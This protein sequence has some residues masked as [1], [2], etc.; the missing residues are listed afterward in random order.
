MRGV[1]LRF[2]SDVLAK[3]KLIRLA[4]LAGVLAGLFAAGKATGVIDNVSI[5][6]VRAYIESAGP[7]G[8]LVFIGAF[9]VGQLVYLPGMA[10][11]AAGILVYGK[12]L[13]FALGWIAAVISVNFSFILVRAVGGKALAEVERPL[14]RKMMAR[15]DRHPITTVTVL[16]TI[17]AM[18][19]AL[20]YA[21]ALS[22][23]KLRDHLIGSMLG[24]IPQI[25]GAALLFEWIFSE[26]L[27]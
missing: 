2:D 24:L 18:A 19:P 3:R 17:F 10:F 14:V 26:V 1:L 23:V 22:S 15:L 4:I 27:R 11:V 9:A 16:R 25:A 21:F 7:L 13:G 20:N 8:F 6:S 12:V 5:E